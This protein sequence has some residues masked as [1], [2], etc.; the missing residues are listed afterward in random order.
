MASP[1][2]DVHF[3]DR[4]PLPPTQQF[5]DAYPPGVL[6]A[7]NASGTGAAPGAARSSGSRPVLVDASS[8][9]LHTAAAAPRLRHVAPDARFVIVLQVGTP[10]LRAERANREI[11]GCR[12][13]FGQPLS[14]V[15]T[16]EYRAPTR[17]A[18]PPQTQNN[19]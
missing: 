18:T 13:H 1:L 7:V 9:Y 10:Q 11:Q 3:F 12:E 16:K 5:L 2:S 6:A 14:A 8:S 17:W 15:T 19:L 4:W